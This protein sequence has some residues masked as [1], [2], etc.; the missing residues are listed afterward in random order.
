MP[1][2]LSLSRAARLA[3]VSRSEI[4]KEIRLGNLM[5]FEGEVRLSHL[6]KVYPHIS[7]ENTAMLER[8][9][10]IQE[11]AAH[12]L[13]N[14]AP[15]SRRKLMNE[16]ERLQLALEDAHIHIDKYHE[17][18]LTLSKR[19]EHIREQNDCPHEQKMVLQALVTWIYSQIQQQKI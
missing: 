7:L 1:E 9:E 16:I 4:Q 13:P 17:L 10:R 15:P 6:Q 12:K 18:V 14:A 5:T 11:R 19:L 3:G 2:L 8:L